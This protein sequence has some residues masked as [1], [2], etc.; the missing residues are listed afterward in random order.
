MFNYLRDTVCTVLFWS[1]IN[2]THSTVA[3]AMLHK[4]SEWMTIVASGFI[5]SME[6]KG[7][8]S[9]GYQ[10]WLIL[11]IWD[12]SFLAK[13]W[14]L[15]PIWGLWFPQKLLNV[16][17]CLV[18]KLFKLCIIPKIIETHFHQLTSRSGLTCCQFGQ[19]LKRP[20]V[21]PVTFVGALLLCF[22]FFY[23]N[24]SYVGNLTLVCGPGRYLFI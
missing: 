7:L 14:S 8:K 15:L 12:S 21:V 24:C 4:Q 22:F 10:S 18:F 9:K 16:Q 23:L 6:Y 19:V 13:F 17:K 3:V 5:P 11:S 20:V 1:S 2:L